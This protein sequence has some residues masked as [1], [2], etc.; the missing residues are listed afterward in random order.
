MENIQVATRLKP[1]DETVWGIHPPHHLYSLQKRNSTQRTTFTFDNC[2]GPEH[3]NA[4]V[5]T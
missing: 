4:D 1:D 3:T 5:Y 2:Y